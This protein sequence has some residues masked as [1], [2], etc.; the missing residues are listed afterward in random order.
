AVEE[1]VEQTRLRRGVTE[2]D[3][4][5]VPGPFLAELSALQ[6]ARPPRHRVERIAELVRKTGEE[7]VLRLIGRLRRRE[8]ALRL[9][10]DPRAFEG[11]HELTRHQLG[12][13]A[14]S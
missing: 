7:L 3:L 6:H 10:L 2:D 8:C 11:D 4:D 13:A 1:I 12:E 14:I 5:G 9:L